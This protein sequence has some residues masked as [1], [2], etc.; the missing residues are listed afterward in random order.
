MK[1]L[2]VCAVLALVLAPSAWAQTP[3]GDAAMGH[4][5]ARDLCAQ[6]HIVEDPQTPPASIGAPTFFDIANNPAITVMSLKAFLMTPHD[7][8][9]NFVIGRGDIDN[10]ISYI[11]SLR[12]TDRRAQPYAPTKPRQ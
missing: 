1:K 8:M 7:R 12:G 4:M 6:C 9:P 2:F 5:F 11:L 10:V 3:T